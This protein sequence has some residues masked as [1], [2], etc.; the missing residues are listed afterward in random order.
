MS[1]APLSPTP[2]RT[3]GELRVIRQYVEKGGR[4]R[5]RQACLPCDAKR[6]QKWREANRERSREMIRNRR[7]VRVYGITAE[8]RQEAIDRRDGKCDICGQ[9]P[10]QHWKTPGERVLHIDHD[11]TTGAI[12]GMLCGQCNKLLAWYEKNKENANDYLTNP[13]TLSGQ[14]D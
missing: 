8:E 5:Y 2:C 13:P 11:H 6:S 10:G 14:G 3:C 7:W 12:R 4:T 1:L 9:E